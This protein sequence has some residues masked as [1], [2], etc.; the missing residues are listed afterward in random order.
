MVD[1]CPVCGNLNI[2]YE[3]ERRRWVCATCGWKWRI[4]ECITDEV[5]YKID[6]SVYHPED[7]CATQEDDLEDDF[8]LLEDE[9]H[10]WL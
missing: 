10:L 4:N 7:P 9:D 5:S 2:R 6:R 8:A 3:E 1:R